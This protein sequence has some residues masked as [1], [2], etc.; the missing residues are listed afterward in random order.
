MMDTNEI[1]KEVE[2]LLE[3]SYVQWLELKPEQ[4]QVAEQPQC[5]PAP[6]PTQVTSLEKP[7]PAPK[8][9]PARKSNLVGELVVNAFI[10]LLLTALS[11]R[12]ANQ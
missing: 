2:N 1:L 3:N 12:L 9:V 6:V 5:L 8:Q 10:L 11:D 7:L 4:V